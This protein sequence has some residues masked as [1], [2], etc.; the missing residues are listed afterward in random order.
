MSG[1]FIGVLNNGRADE[2]RDALRGYDV[3]M[4]ET[5]ARHGGPPAQTAPTATGSEDSYL[6]RMPIGYS[7]QVRSIFPRDA[8]EHAAEISFRETGWDRYA[9]NT[10]GEDSRGL[11]QI[12]VGPG[13]NP[14]LLSLGDLFDPSTN[15]Q[16]ARIVW[17]RQGWAAWYNAATA[18]GFVNTGPGEE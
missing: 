6:S 18:A 9:H 8:W 11:F 1:F 5:V 4:L 15:V 10:N 13:G 7:V 3:D 17:E 2:V 14:D 16:A 12:N